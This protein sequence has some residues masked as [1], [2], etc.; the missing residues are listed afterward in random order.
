MNPGMF[1]RMVI[2]ER[3]TVTNTN[4]SVSRAWATLQG[5]VPAWKRPTGGNESVSAD[6]F[7]SVNR[8]IWQTPWF[9]DLTVKDRINDGG[10]YWNI[11]SIVELGR[12]AGYQIT[13]RLND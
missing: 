6:K 1:D 10:S 11:E 3:V 9:N 8:A 4:G 7:E 5:R 12:R 13:A 2:I